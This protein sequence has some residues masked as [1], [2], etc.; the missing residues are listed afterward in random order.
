MFGVGPVGAQGAPEGVTG[1]LSYNGPDGKVP[2]AGV[3]IRIL[4]A[5][6]NE[7]AVGASGED[8]SIAIDLPG[9]GTYVAEIVTDTFPEGVALR[10]P[11]TTTREITANANQKRP[12]LF[13]LVEGDGGG[14]ATGSFGSEL[15]QLTFD[16]IKFGMI[17]AMCSIGLSLIFGT[18][19]LTNF[20][21]GE[22]VTFGAL[23]ALLLNPWRSAHHPGRLPGRRCDRR[24]RC[25]Q[26]ATVVATAASPGHRV[27]RPARHLDRPEHPRSLHHVVLCRWP[28]GTLRAVR[29]PEGQIL[30]AD[31]G[32]QS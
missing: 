10:D 11:E 12:V 16:G 18:T 3:E 31:H 24:R 32:G 28:K 30:R 4:D 21:H 20:A 17:I 15:A 8:G 6:G 29:P 23:F 14:S 25:G 7:V 1:T 22:L 26:R 2:V 13:P 27:D 9:P 19:G 5:D